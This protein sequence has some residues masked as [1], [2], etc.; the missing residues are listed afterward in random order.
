[1]LEATDLS[2]ILTETSAEFVIEYLPEPIREFVG[3]FNFQSY[4][5]WF[6]FHTIKLTI[7]KGKMTGLFAASL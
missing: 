4:R 6:S 3:H 2:Q 5:T 1:M 7:E